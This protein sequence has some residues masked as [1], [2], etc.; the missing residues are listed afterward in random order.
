MAA[1]EPGAEIAWREGTPAGSLAVDLIAASGGVPVEMRGRLLVAR[2]SAVHAAC[3]T[4]RR[5]Q[6]AMQGLGG[7]SPDAAVAVTALVQT[8]DDSTSDRE[9]AAL[10]E[11][12]KAAAGKILLGQRAGQVLEQEPGFATRNGGKGALELVW[13]APD[14]QTSRAADELAMARLN[15]ENPPIHNSG[16]ERAA[17]PAAG[18]PQQL[19]SSDATRIIAA[20]GLDRRSLE[21]DE[22]TPRR[23]I[24]RWALA[25]AAAIVLLTGG[26]YAFSHGA[27]ASVTPGAAVNSAP[28]ASQPI[29]RAAS[30][31]AVPPP[32]APAVSA[33]SQNP[34]GPDTSAGSNPKLS[35][36]EKA[37]L[38]AQQ[39]QA[40]SRENTKP[41][42][43]A[44]PEAP[45]VVA[46]GDCQY[47]PDQFPGLLA[48][49]ENSR[50]R[51]QYQDAKRKFTA[52][53][54]CDRAN[55]RAQEGL[56][57]V[58]QAIKAEGSDQ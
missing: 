43:T 39:A 31:P 9:G 34:V 50:A 53:L 22:P 1:G 23:P 37:K 12:E 30:T 52:V 19:V 33:A 18:D 49:A 24:A 40:A 25:A 26:Y 35:R 32:S 14:E 4:A 3:L 48:R 51:G 7:Y 36:R 11:L 45:K 57:Q 27:K 8:G 20:P 47:Q 42:P 58:L 55:S 6:W 5:L 28:P 44:Q 38:E 13:R 54:A 16:S 29:P 21:A 10:S 56:Q 41:Q 46:G 2:F 15:G 17:A